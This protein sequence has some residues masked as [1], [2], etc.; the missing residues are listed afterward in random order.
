MNPSI[1]NVHQIKYLHSDKQHT[2]LENKLKVLM[3][4][5]EFPPSM[6]GG[7]GVA[8]FGLSKALSQ[9]VD[10][11]IV[12]PKTNGIK[13]SFS[14]N[15][16]GANTV[17]PD[18]DLCQR[19]EKRYE[20]FADVHYIYANVSPYPTAA[21][22]IQKVRL[23]PALEIN[24]NQILHVPKTEDKSSKFT[25]ANTLKWLNEEEVYG[26]NIL[27]KV[28]TYTE[29][30]LEI[31]RKTDFDVIHA[32]DWMTFPAAAAIKQATGKPLVAHV[33][34]LETD[35]IHPEARGSIY[36][37]EQAGMTAAD[38]VIP[39]SHYTKNKISDYYEIDEDKIKPVHNGLDGS[40]LIK[41]EMKDEFRYVLFLGRM[42]HQKG[43]E[44]LVETAE[45]LCKKMPDVRFLVAGD[46]DKLRDTMKLARQKGIS[47]KMQFVGFLDRKAVAEAISKADAYFMP[48]VS[49][50]FGLSALEAAKM[51]VPVVISKQSGVSEVLDGA[52][53]ANY[54]DTSRF[55]NYLYAILNYQGIKKEVISLNDKDLSELSWEKAA[56]EVYMYYLQLVDKS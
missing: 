51:Q 49:E 40:E 31:A 17:L 16:E 45:K 18:K 14:A 4:G 41:K 5:W 54:W 34:S 3:L 24:E 38:I 39:V 1:T 26:E 32:H 11:T 6:A 44:Y 23:N 15:F 2:I 33:H 25:P 10:L 37:L 46:G 52:L 53:K 12:L 36:Q 29:A 35:R 9:Y 13:A 27:Q 48:S 47:D 28:A 22:L 55:A 8:S 42:T 20:S 43:T 19:I 30:A 56:K 21:P 50:P 7:L